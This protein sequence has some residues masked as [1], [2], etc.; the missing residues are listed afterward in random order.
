VVKIEEKISKVE[1]LLEE[2]KSG[3]KSQTEAIDVDKIVDIVYNKVIDKISKEGVKITL[4]PAEYIL[5][6][7]QEN[8]VRRWEE[9]LEQLDSEEKKIGAFVIALGRQTTRKEILGKVFG[10]SYTSGELYMT[11]TKKIDKLIE[12]GIIR[13]DKAGRIYPA[14]EDN[15]RNTLETYNPSE[16]KIQEV[17]DR[18]KRI[19]IEKIEEEN[20]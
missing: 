15:V 18:I 1:K 12:L 6:K 9:K 8:E 20:E 14:I 2:I 17:M 3:F 19:F 5:N 7:F 13:T 16:E 4:P 10:A 11:Y